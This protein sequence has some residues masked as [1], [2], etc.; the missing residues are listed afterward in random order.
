MPSKPWIFPLVFPLI[1]VVGC[2]APKM[3]KPLTRELAG[4]DPDAQVNFW[5]SLADEH[6]TTNDQAFHGLL[7]YADGK[8]DNADYAARVATLKARKWLPSGFKG[9]ADTGVHRGDVAVAVMRIL[10]DKGG[11]TI[12]VIGPVPRYA[13]RELMF[14]DVFPPS[15]T[16]QTFSGNEFVGIMGRVEDFQFGNTANVSA[17]VMPDEMT[18]SPASTQAVRE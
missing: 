16:N 17:S 18:S 8:D 13:V 2:A 3:G 5:H 9:T 1:L 4:N 15:S 7:L 12:H 10:K 11:L 6:V 14:L